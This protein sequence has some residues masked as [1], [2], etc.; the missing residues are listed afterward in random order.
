MFLSNCLSYADDTLLFS[1]DEMQVKMKHF[2]EYCKEW[3]DLTIL[4]GVRQE[5][6]N[7]LSVEYLSNFMHNVLIII[8]GISEKLY[9]YVQI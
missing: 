6:T 8:S 4:A 7:Y 9:K 2:E 5:K 3:S 1:A